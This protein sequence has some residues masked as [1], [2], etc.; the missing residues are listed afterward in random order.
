MSRP[1]PAR[2]WRRPGRVLVVVA[3]A[4]AGAAGAVASGERSSPLPVGAEA[5]EI[6]LRD[7]HGRAFR[8]S[9]TLAS[10]DFVVVAFYV[11]AFTGG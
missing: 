11:K 3:L 5:P 1:A 9:D 4:L 8:L 10:R 2:S 6:E 7:Q